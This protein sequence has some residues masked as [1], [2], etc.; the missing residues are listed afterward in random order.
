[1]FAAIGLALAA[2][3]IGAHNGQPPSDLMSIGEVAELTRRSL[4]A[5]Y[6]LRY[7]GSGPPSFRLGRRLVYR[8]ADVL[9][10]ID[11][12]AAADKYLRRVGR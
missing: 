4:N 6:S 3:V 2:A 11:A 5:L 1:M 12:N 8:R 9:A 10:W 7:R